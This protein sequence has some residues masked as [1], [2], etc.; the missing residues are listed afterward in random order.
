LVEYL[1]GFCREL[2]KLGDEVTLLVSHR[3]EPLIQEQLGALA[4]LPES[5]F[6]KMSDGAPAW[7]RYARIP[8]HAWKTFWALRKF[9]KN[10]AA[11]DVIFVPTVIV[12]HLLGWTMLVKLGILPKRARL[13]LFFPNLPIRKSN[14]AVTLDG[15][16][17]SRILRLLLLTLN[18]EIVNGRLLLG[19]ETHEMKEAA[20]KVF[21][22]PFIYF[23]IPLPPSQAP[24]PTPIFH[25]LSRWPATVLRVMK[26][27]VICWFGALCAIWKN[28]PKVRLALSFNGWRTLS[29]RMGKRSLFLIPEEAS[30]V[31]IVDRFFCRG[32]YAD[33]LA[34]T[35]ILLLPYRGSSYGLRVSRV[36]IEALV[37]GIPVVAT[38]G[39]TLARQAQEH[40]V[41][42]HC[43]DE[44]VESLVA[45]IEEMEHHC[46]GGTV[47]ASGRKALAQEHF[48]VSHFRKLL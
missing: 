31:E 7:K 8:F 43:E 19:V 17:T 33:R 9:L 22:V 6:S 14:D 24:P 30:R 27:G 28:I 26:R 20:E 5:A 2:P 1:E 44:D 36:V 3:A 32:E 45:A 39:T 10:S 4:V 34:A 47:A 15:S 13:L 35:Q 37:N 12:H 29:G 23:P 38:R 40:G 11:L 21:G 18:A 25:L 41:A 46:E 42:L 48:S 16:P